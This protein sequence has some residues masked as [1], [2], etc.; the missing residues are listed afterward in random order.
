LQEDNVLNVLINDKTDKWEETTILPKPVIIVC[1]KL[2]KRTSFYKTYKDV[3]VEFNYIDKPT[4]IKNMSAMVK[5]RVSEGEIDAVANKYAPVSTIM[6]ELEK[7]AMNVGYGLKDT[8]PAIDIRT[9]DEWASSFI[10][11]DFPEIPPDASLMGILFKVNSHLSYPRGTEKYAFNQSQ[12]IRLKLV[13]NDVLNGI[14]SG[15]YT[16]RE[17]WLWLTAKK[18]QIRGQGR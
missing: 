5:E 1:N 12:I 16:Y 3:T 8:P 6:W 11:S 17:A 10:I 14:I 18:L 2:D 9:V 13:I 15:L 7:I 4:I